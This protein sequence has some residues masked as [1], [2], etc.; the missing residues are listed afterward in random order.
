MT[1]ASRTPDSSANLSFGRLVVLVR[2]YG[3]ALAFY[4]AAFGAQVLFDAASPDGGRYLH[5]TLGGDMMDRGDRGRPSAGIWL[6][7]ASDAD[8]SLVGRQAG[9]QPLAVLYASDVR[10]ALRRAEAAGASV[11]RPLVEADGASFAHVA[12]LYGNEYVLVELAAA[13]GD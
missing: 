1:H 7:Q 2:D 4:G 13:P 6:L 11:V 3:E 10:A 12:D 9:R 8:S 5:L